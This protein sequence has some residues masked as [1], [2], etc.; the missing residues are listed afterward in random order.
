MYAAS[1]VS[2]VLF[3]ALCRDLGYPGLSTEDR[4]DPLR[5]GIPPESGL[6]QFRRLSAIA[7]AFKKSEVESSESA[8]LDSLN[9]F[10]AANEACSKRS[11][12]EFRTHDYSVAAGLA[13]SSARMYLWDWFEQQNE[14][15]SPITMASI[16]TAARF[17]PGRSVGLKEKPSL[18]YFKVGDS[19]QTASSTFI[20]SWY[21]SSVTFNPLCEAAEMARKARCGAAEVREYGLLSFVPKKYSR[22]RIVVTEPSLNTYFQLGVGSRME[23]VLQKRAGINFTLEPAHNQQLAK[24]GSVYGGYA[25]MDLTQCSDYISLELVKFMFPPSLVRWFKILRTPSVKVGKG[26]VLPL[27][28]TSTMGNG[29]TF[30]LQ[31]ALLAACVRGVYR[32]L[33]IPHREEITDEFGQSSY[34]RTWGVFGDDIVIVPEAY[35]LLSEVL[36]EL[37]LQVNESKSFN[38]GPFRE[39]CGADYYKGVN[40]RPVYFKR[41]ET[42]QDLISCFNRLAIWSA[43]TGECVTETLSLLVR[44]IRDV[45][46]AIPI[47]PPDSG[48]TAGIISPEPPSDPVEGLWTYSAFT[49]KIGS[50]RFEP[51]EKYSTGMIPSSKQKT[52]RFKKWLSELRRVCSGSIN[53]PALLKALLQGSVRKSRMAPR[54]ETVTYRL[55]HGLTTPRWGWSGLDGIPEIGTPRFGRWRN[56]VNLALSTTE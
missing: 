45:C 3:P 33:D 50:I 16:E 20:R 46:P 23:E 36:A 19:C 7:A 25:T 17:G 11:A 22:K 44:L 24:R 47:V 31:T 42:V 5:F 54:L 12:K 51:W 53:E 8:T 56:I 10:L 13:V 49:P 21:E 28:M 1:D 2:T 9:D 55:E 14:P 27:Y 34:E 4:F 40:V 18:Y 52:K 35:E 39:S 38:C 6:E 29:F 30:P 26:A 37:G 43:N 48:V 41:Y 15:D 32:T